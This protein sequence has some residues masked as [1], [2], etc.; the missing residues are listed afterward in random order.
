MEERI[1]SVITR[2]G[3]GTVSIDES[4]LG[5]E[6]RDALGPSAAPA[7]QTSL[8]KQEGKARVVHNAS[9]A[10]LSPPEWDEAEEVAFEKQLEEAKAAST[11]Q[12]Q[13]NAAGEQSNVVDVEFEKEL[14]MAMEISLAEQRGFE[15]G[16]LQA[17]AKWREGEEP[18]SAV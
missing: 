5:P 1:Q 4:R 18:K 14:R 11:A 12:S 10:I 6:A 8:Q 13:S 15:H 2:G 3:V 17:A 9:D 7:A 16:L